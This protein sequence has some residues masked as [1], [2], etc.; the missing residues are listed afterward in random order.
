MSLIIDSKETESNGVVFYIQ[1]E[2]DQHSYETLD[3]ALEKATDD[4]RCKIH[5]NLSKVTYISSAGIGVLVG[6]AGRVANEAD[7]QF[8]L[9]CPSPTVMGVLD[10][11][12]FSQFFTIVAAPPQT[13]AA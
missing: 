4:G 10:S 3:E 7:G 6:C 5:I 2:I 9:H 1:G 12:G 13:H 11:M 8:E